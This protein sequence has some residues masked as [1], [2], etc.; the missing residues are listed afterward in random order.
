MADIPNDGLIIYGPGYTGKKILLLQYLKQPLWKEYFWK[1]YWINA[2]DEDNSFN[3]ILK[4]EFKEDQ[5]DGDLLAKY[6]RGNLADFIP[7][8]YGE[9]KILLVYHSI[10]SFP[11]FQKNFEYRKQQLGEAQCNIDIFRFC[12]LTRDTSVSRFEKVLRINRFTLSESVK[13][14]SGSIPELAGDLRAQTLAEKLA[15]I[16]GNHPLLISNAWRL[17]EG[18]SDEDFHHTCETLVKPENFELIYKN[19]PEFCEIWKRSFDYFWQEVKRRSENNKP[20]IDLGPIK[21]LAAFIL[22]VFT[23]LDR[24]H[25]CANMFKSTRRF[26]QDKSIFPSISEIGL[27][28]SKIPSIDVYDEQ[29]RPLQFTKVLEL[30]ASANFLE[31]YPGGKEELCGKTV[32][33]MP[34]TVAHWLENYMAEENFPFTHQELLVIATYFLYESLMVQQVNDIT[35][36][37]M[38]Y[39]VTQGVVTSR[40]R[41]LCLLHHFRKVSTGIL[42]FSDTHGSKILQLSDDIQLSM[43]DIT[44]LFL[45]VGAVLIAH[46]QLEEAERLCHAVLEWAQNAPDYPV[47]LIIKV[48]TTL[49]ELL[50]EVEDYKA[51]LEHFEEIVKEYAGD[52]ADERDKMD[53]KDKITAKTN[54]Y[55]AKV[56]YMNDFSAESKQDQNEQYKETLEDLKQLKKRCKTYNSGQEPFHMSHPQTIAIYTNIANV[57]TLQK[58]YTSALKKLDKCG[59]LLTNFSQS[60]EKDKKQRDIYNY[61]IYVSRGQLSYEYAEYIR[62]IDDKSLKALLQ[63]TNSSK[64]PTTKAKNGFKFWKQKSK[65]SEYLDQERFSQTHIDYETAA[66]NFEKAYKICK[67][68]CG[69]SHME[70]LQ[71]IRRQAKATFGSHNFQKAINLCNNLLASGSGENGDYN[72]A[73][74]IPPLMPTYVG[75]WTGFFWSDVDVCITMAYLCAAREKEAQED[76]KRDLQRALEHIERADKTYNDAEKE[77]STK[78]PA[79]YVNLGRSITAMRKDISQDPLLA[80]TT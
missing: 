50:F 4:D 55:A 17:L 41:A 62:N 27:T 31:E 2:K 37:Y 43:V 69:A 48:K 54:L 68:A 45:N 52:K 58:E 34:E 42:T 14:L 19:P 71:L 38:M 9:R 21:T 22:L 16:C 5:S 66:D 18:N 75:R 47:E 13:L 44:K 79:Q 6:G 60:R 23:K 33:R 74:K 76:K 20:Q 51:A 59:K 72:D 25:I 32:Y 10:D 53:E 24:N 67:A 80:T 70:T 46:S 26:G 35:G 63:K 12:F 28:S 15:L 57:Y 30:L 7:K 8:R 29:L 39:D 61:I 11:V 56:Q 78:L 64:K 73:E 40:P 49:A 3:L 77:L 65:T 36:E 1:V